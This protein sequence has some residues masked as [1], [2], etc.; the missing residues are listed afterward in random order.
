MSDAPL[1][2]WLLTGDPA[3]R[4]LR[5]AFEELIER[6][7][8]E[9]IPLLRAVLIVVGQNAE[10]VLSS[11]SD[12]GNCNQTDGCSNQLFRHLISCGEHRDGHLA[13]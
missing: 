8:G 5:T 10:S 3:A 9:D 1:A 13:H 11:N 4:D 6:L 12:I 7:D 2:H